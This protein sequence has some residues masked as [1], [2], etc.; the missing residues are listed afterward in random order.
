MNILHECTSET[1]MLE[2]SLCSMPLEEL[3]SKVYYENQNRRLEEKNIPYSSFVQTSLHLSSEGQ[4]REENE[5]ENERGRNW[6]KHSR[7]LYAQ[8]KMEN[9]RIRMVSSECHCH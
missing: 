1:K 9:F 5:E 8:S 6:E 7:M 4:W 2:A 3:L